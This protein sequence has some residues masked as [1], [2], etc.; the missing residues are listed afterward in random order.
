MKSVLVD[1]SECEW[2]F[3]V[4]SFSLSWKQQCCSQTAKSVLMSVGIV[5]FYCMAL[6]VQGRRL[7]AKPWHKI[8]L[9]IL[10]V[11]K[12]KRI[13]FLHVYNIIIL[14]HHCL[15]Q[16]IKTYNVT[17]NLQNAS[18]IFG[19]IHGFPVPFSGIQ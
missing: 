12:C 14:Y 13:Y 7:Y 5:L 18:E 11:L 6:L 3:S 16:K 10:I 9:H 4:F 19:S 8:I 15:S 1:S 17:A 2:K